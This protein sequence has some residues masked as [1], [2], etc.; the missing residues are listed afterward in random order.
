MHPHS[1]N[2]P[3]NTN[4]PVYYT[5]SS[6][7]V[8]TIVSKQLVQIV[9]T[10]F[11]FGRYKGLPSMNKIFTHMSFFSNSTNHSTFI[12]IAHFFHG[13]AKAYV[14]PEDFLF[15]CIHLFVQYVTHPSLSAK[16]SLAHPHVC[17]TYPA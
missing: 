4:S 9:F 6:F 7:I 12:F 16:L 1:R 13:L 3:L 2:H 11:L 14:N 17:S 10:S 15:L 5:N 8:S